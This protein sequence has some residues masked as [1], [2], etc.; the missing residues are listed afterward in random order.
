M[1]VCAG[2]HFIIRQA[3]LCR[4]PLINGR[5]P[6]RAWAAGPVTAGPGGFAWGLF[7]FH[8][9]GHLPSAPPDTPL[10]RPPAAAFQP[11]LRSAA[12]NYPIHSADLFGIQQHSLP[13][14][15]TINSIVRHQY[16]TALAQSIFINR[17][18][19]RQPCRRNY[20]QLNNA[21][22]ISLTA[23]IPAL[24]RRFKSGSAA[25]DAYG[26]DYAIVAPATPFAQRH[27]ATGS[28]RI[29]R[30]SHQHRFI[31]QPLSTRPR[32]FALQ[33]YPPLATAHHCSRI[34]RR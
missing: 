29:L 16:S 15:R 31:A 18:Q 10:R 19:R 21:T 13:L 7:G 25:T 8:P 12:A 2:C 34:A 1:C 14:A 5:A 24:L 6:A 11:Q 22:T 4:Q 30:H 32:L 26:Q 3:R 28:Q 23:T 20:F 17:R 9:P 27:A 33:R